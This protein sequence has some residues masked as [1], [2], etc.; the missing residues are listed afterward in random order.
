MAVKLLYITL[1]AMNSCVIVTYEYDAM[2]HSRTAMHSE[3]EEET[4]KTD[5]EYIAKGHEPT[6]RPRSSR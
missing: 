6:D 1:T 4:E 3:G 2:L 5:R